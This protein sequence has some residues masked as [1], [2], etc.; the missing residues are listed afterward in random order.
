MSFCTYGQRST[1]KC[2]R[3]NVHEMEQN[4]EVPGWFAHCL[5]DV[6]AIIRTVPMQPNFCDCADSARTTALVRMT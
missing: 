6:I 3:S 1:L 2:V 4:V 5:Y